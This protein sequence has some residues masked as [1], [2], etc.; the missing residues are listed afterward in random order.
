MFAILVLSLLALT[1]GKNDT[2]QMQYPVGE[3]SGN[4]T[5]HHTGMMLTCYIE[6]PPELGEILCS[7][8][9]AYK[10]EGSRAVLP[11]VLVVVTFMC[12]SFR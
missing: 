10:S 12:I 7:N 3:S 5:E 1:N 6:D 8:N 9:V 4:S 11:L 2:T